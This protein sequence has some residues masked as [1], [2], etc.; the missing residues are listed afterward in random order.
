MDHHFGL[1]DHAPPMRPAQGG[2]AGL[3]EQGHGLVGRAPVLPRAPEQP[4]ALD[5]GGRRPG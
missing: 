1:H 5:Q 3:A 2:V 4:A